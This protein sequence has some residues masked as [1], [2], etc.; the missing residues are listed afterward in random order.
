MRRRRILAFGLGLLATLAA[1]VAAQN[2]AGIVMESRSGRPVEGARVAGYAIP[3]NPTRK[4]LQTLLDA[5]AGTARVTTFAST[6]S[7]T[8]R[9]CT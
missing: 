4:E 2:V 5:T 8:L 9:P 7:P 6:F 1:R 3:K